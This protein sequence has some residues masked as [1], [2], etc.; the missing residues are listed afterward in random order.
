MNLDIKFI[1]LWKLSDLLHL[2]VLFKNCIILFRLNLTPL[3]T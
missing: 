3:G 1:K 2:I